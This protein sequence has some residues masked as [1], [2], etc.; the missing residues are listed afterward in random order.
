MKTGTMNE[1]IRNNV[2]I[3]T[4][5][6]I[7]MCRAD[8]APLRDRVTWLAKRGVTRVVLDLS[9]LKW[10]GA[11]MLGELVSNQQLLQSAGGDLRLACASDRIGKILSVTRLADRFRTFKTADHAVASFGEKTAIQ[12]A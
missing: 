8:L 4:V 1:E 11:A 2:A 9:R 12:A 3:L 6:D 5:D 7:P 10:F